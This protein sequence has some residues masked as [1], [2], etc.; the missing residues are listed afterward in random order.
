MY[1]IPRSY[2]ELEGLM[3]VFVGS[4]LRKLDRTGPGS[5]TKVEIILK[6]ML[7]IKLD[8][9]LNNIDEI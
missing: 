8:L 7:D 2:L 4:C 6:Q 5:S 9:S 1:Y 3:A